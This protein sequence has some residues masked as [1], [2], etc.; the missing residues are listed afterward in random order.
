MNQ[1]ADDVLSPQL[2][3]PDKRRVPPDRGIVLLDAKGRIGPQIWA[4]YGKVDS[5]VILKDDKYLDNRHN[6]FYRDDKGRAFLL[7]PVIAADDTDRY[8]KVDAVYRR[9]VGLGVTENAMIFFTCV[10]Q[11][12]IPDHCCIAIHSASGHD[13][14][15]EDKCRTLMRFEQARVGQDMGYIE[16]RVDATKKVKPVSIISDIPATPNLQFAANMLVLHHRYSALQLQAL[17]DE[18]GFVLT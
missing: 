5:P 14:L 13:V 16:F 8:E 10:Y 12:D 2:R 11:F 15:A 3:D 4:L 7:L 9:S 17:W 1:Q 18:A 6:E